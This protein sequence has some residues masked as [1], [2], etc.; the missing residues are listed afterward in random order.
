MKTGM[1]FKHNNP[2]INRNIE[3]DTCAPTKGDMIL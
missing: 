3:A 2:I 1:N